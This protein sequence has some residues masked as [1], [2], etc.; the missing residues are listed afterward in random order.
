MPVPS[1]DEK[2]GGLCLGPAPRPWKTK[3]A[4]ETRTTATQNEN[5]RYRPGGERIKQRNLR[6]NL[7]SSKN[8]SRI[9]FWNVRT[10]YESGRAAQLAREMEKFRLDIM[11]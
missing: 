9:G 11:G 6:T 7:L 10:L 3:Y 8:V 2:G 4:T 5:L 1:P